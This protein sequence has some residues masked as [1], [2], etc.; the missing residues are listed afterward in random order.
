M[1][2]EKEIKFAGKSGLLAEIKLLNCGLHIMGNDDLEPCLKIE[3]ESITNLKEEEEISEY[4]EMSYDE[5]N[6]KLILSQTEKRLPSLIRNLHLELTIP[7]ET[8]I[9]C[10]NVNGGVKA[11][12]LKL[13]Q[14]YEMVNGGVKSVACSGRLEI[15]CTNGGIKVLDHDGELEL[16]QKN[17]GISIQDSK[18]KMNLENHNGGVKMNHCQGELI[19]EHKNG[20]IKVLNSGLTSAD[21]RTVN[22]N[23][24]YEFAEV[25]AGKFNF[26]NSQGKIHLI[27]PKDMQYDIRA[28]NQHG[29]VIIGLD[30]SYEQK[31]EGEKE[32]KLVN[33]SGSVTIEIANRQGA[34]IL[35]DELHQHE[36][37][38]S[39]VSR[40]IEILLK[41]KIIPSLESMTSE[42]APRIRRQIRKAGEKLSRIEINIPDIE[43]KIKKVLNQVS[44]TISTTLEDN[45]ED[46]EKYKDT[47]INKVNKTWDNISDY[48]AKKKSDVEDELSKAGGHLKKEQAQEV[49]E[50]SKLKILELLE[51]G[52]ITPE[53]AEKLLKALNS[54]KE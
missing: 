7:Q 12:N 13:D 44:E 54:N 26:V 1:K 29:K 37:L 31:G 27:I 41:E 28:K 3:M 46:I 40:K 39:K 30:K 20:G 14:N 11:E 53:D 22:S 5:E 36:E 51:K 23:I 16:E 19:L 9:S 4:V 10:H 50:R 35:L 52:T 2:L 38:E 47:A 34:I 18:G 24:Y 15:H 43:N 42:N 8:E 25:E 33:G 17:G 6:N 21:I 49:N 45:A 48:V 32:F